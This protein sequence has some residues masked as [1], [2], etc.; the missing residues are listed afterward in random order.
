[1]NNLMT[2]ADLGW[3]HEFSPTTNEQRNCRLRLYWAGTGGP[4]MAMA[5]LT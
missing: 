3:K 4:T 2:L 5:K 1:M